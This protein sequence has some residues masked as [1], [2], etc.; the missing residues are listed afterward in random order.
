MKNPWWAA[1]L[2]WALLSSRVPQEPLTV[3]PTDLFSKRYSAATNAAALGSDLSR[4]PLGVFQRK[5]ELNSALQTYMNDV[6]AAR[7]RKGMERT[8]EKWHFFF[9]FSL[10]AIYTDSHE[11]TIP[12][13]HVDIN[14]EKLANLPSTSWVGDHGSRSLGIY[15][16]RHFKREGD[17]VTGIGKGSLEKKLERGEK[18]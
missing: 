3:C 10:F 6:L 7:K 4:E 16:I 11:L 9:H 2:S 5:G 18:S 8:P 1:L 15:R 12:V 17:S 13:V 14:M